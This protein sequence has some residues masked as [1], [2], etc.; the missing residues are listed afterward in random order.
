M[1]GKKVMT[2][3][4]IL[5]ITVLLFVSLVALSF[6]VD[7]AMGT[8]FETAL[9][10]LRTPFQLM[11][12]AEYCVLILFLAVLFGGQIASVW[13]K[14]KNGRQGGRAAK[15]GTGGNS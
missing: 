14:K 4:K 1:D 3:L 7:L 6:A 10:N 8:G 2:M 12:A 13:A 5:G 9:S 11:S 15:K